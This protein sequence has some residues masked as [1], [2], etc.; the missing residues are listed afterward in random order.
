MWILQLKYNTLKVK[1]SF[2]FFW[3]VWL[4]GHTEVGGWKSKV[5]E[6]TKVQDYEG[7]TCPLLVY[8]WVK[9]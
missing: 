5:E 3:V 1:L 4:F 6:R 9:S 8:V 7:V 2:I